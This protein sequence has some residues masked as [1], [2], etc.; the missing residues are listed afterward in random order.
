M[1]ALVLYSKNMKKPY[2]FLL[3]VVLLVVGG[4]TAWYLVDHKSSNDNSNSMSSMDM[5]RSSSS[6]TGNGSSS[7][8]TQSTN[9]VTIQNF[10]FSPAN[11]TVKV[12]TKVTWKNQDSVTHTVTET[13]G[14][15][16]PQSGNVDPGASYSFTFDKAG[17]YH[18]H[19]T[20]HPNMT[21]TVT[22]TN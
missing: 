17:T 8:S 21:G 15:S 6:S 7:S 2:I 10:A 16:G 11:I 5:N 22:V 18:Y 1:I 20:I 14:Q 13:D 12:G 3:L 9:S 4:G 19:C